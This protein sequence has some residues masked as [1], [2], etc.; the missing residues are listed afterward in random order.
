MKKFGVIL[1]WILFLG[2][3][4]AAYGAA[5]APPAVTEGPVTVVCM[6]TA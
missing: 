6:E 1:A 2:A 3:L 4:G 5:A